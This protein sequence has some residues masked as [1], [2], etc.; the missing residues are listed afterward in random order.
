MSTAPSPAPPSDRTPLLV[1]DAAGVC[2]EIPVAPG[3]SLA[4]TVYGSGLFETPPLCAGLGRCGRCRM[5]FLTPPP[6]AGPLERDIL[7]DR[8]VRCGWRLGCRHPALPGLRLRLPVPARPHP[9][10]LSAPGKTPLAL[11]VDLGTTSLCWQAEADAPGADGPVAAGSETNPQMPFGADIMSR[12]SAA[13]DPACGE[14]LRS[15]VVAR[16]ADIIRALGREGRVRE[17]CVAANPAMTALL[18]GSRRIGDLARAPYR[19]PCAGNATGRIPGLE[20]PV[21]LP[22]QA[23][24]FI[25]G[26]ISAGMSVLLADLSPDAYPFLFADLGTNG[27]FVLA[28]SPTVTLSASVPLGPALEGIGL[29]CGRTVEKDGA[30]C[31]TAF[32]LSPAGPIASCPAP[33]SPLGI[34]ATG[35]LSLLALLL[36]Q[37]VV[38][39]AGAF[40]ADPPSPLGRRIAAGLRMEGGAL[41]P[42]ENG[43][44]LSA[45]DIEEILKV[46]AAFTFAVSS[47]L[48]QGG[49][50]TAA[51]RGWHAGGALG[52][53]VRPGDL[54][55]LG[56]LPAG[57]ALSF[58]PHG[59]LSLEGAARMLGREKNRYRDLAADWAGRTRVID[60]TR[61]PAGA[62]TIIDH[63]RFV[64]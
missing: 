61:S 2:H 51:V 9:A 55:T 25:G 41:L 58:H 52:R 5:R 60:L 64:F 19:L 1:E 63:M 30:G 3:Q 40:R 12:V 31:A 20:P 62:E 32:R 35:Y 10:P 48:A 57:G 43:L 17:L 37:G 34:S 54:E 15:L 39:T 4:Q 50:G 18:L 21:Y 28:L 6:E 14:R 24:P 33:S 36:S 42:L 59:N 8:N 46:K 27:E 7:G 47:L 29:S 26:D 38:T 53:H 23:A 13:A 16:L 11:A 49:I 45:L 22:A 44:F 56:F